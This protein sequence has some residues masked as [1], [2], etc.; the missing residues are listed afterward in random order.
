MALS[1][2]ATKQVNSTAK[3]MATIMQ[4]LDYLTTQE[5][6]IMTYNSSNMMLQVHSDAGYENKKKAQSCTGVHFFLSNN[7][8]SA[9]NNGAILTVVTI[10]KAVM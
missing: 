8:T 2:L 6:A 4:L 9:P 3:T 1:S 5:D 7:S 10:I